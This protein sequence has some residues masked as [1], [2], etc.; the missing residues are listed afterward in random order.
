MNCALQSCPC[1][2]RLVDIC[3]F[4]RAL[5]ICGKAKYKVYLQFHFICG[6]YRKFDVN[7]TLPLTAINPQNFK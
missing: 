1:S 3:G 2:G 5:D 4:L 6:F 7:P